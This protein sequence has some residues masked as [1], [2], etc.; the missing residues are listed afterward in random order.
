MAKEEYVDLKV[1]KRIREEKQA[2]FNSIE[3]GVYVKNC[4]IEYEPVALFD[5]KMS[6]FLPKG[7]LPMPEEY[8]KLKYPS[9]RRPQI[10]YTNQDGSVNFAFSH[11]NMP[12]ERDETIQAIEQFKNIIKKVN[13]ANILYEM[14]EENLGDT[15]LSWFDFKGYAI[16]GQSYNLMYVTPLEKTVM[17]GMFNCKFADAAEWKKA[18][19]PAILSIVDLTVKKGD[20]I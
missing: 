5:H 2:A 11:F 18:V 7:L 9:E 19:L 20:E 14:K 16:D 8:A 12:I 4:L 1:V 10:I 13:P 17:H 6:I 3:T 15:K